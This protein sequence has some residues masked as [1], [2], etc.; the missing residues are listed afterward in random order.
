MKHTVAT[1]AAI[2]AI[3]ALLLGTLLPLWTAVPVL[4]QDDSTGTPGLSIQKYI[5]PATPITPPISALPGAC[6][7]ANQ[8]NDA[9]IPVLAPGSAVTWVYRVNYDTCTGV[10]A[11]PTYAQAQVIVDDT[12]LGDVIAFAGEETGNGDTTFEYQEVWLY[13]A[14][15]TV[16]DLAGQA[17]DGTNTVNGCS[18]ASDGQGSR[19]TYR[20][21]ASVTAPLTSNTDVAHYCNPVAPTPTP[22]ITTTPVPSPTPTATSQAPTPTFTPEPER[23]VQIPEPVTVVLFGTGLAA[24]SAAMATRRKK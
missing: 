23:P 17:V 12:R 22:T 19:P 2:V 18:A 15:G 3:L 24:L 14:T 20:N 7:D 1:R 6:V 13:F 5:C 10:G 8:A 21:S 16:A 4:A 9:T 11:C